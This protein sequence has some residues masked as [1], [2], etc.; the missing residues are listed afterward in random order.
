MSYLEAI[1]AQIKI[2]N[3]NKILQLW[4]EYCA[5][6]KVDPIEL[7][8]ILKAF[9]ASDFAKSMGKY[10]EKGL[11]LWK[12]IE[13]SQQ[14]YE[15]L[16]QLIDLQTTNNAALA[17]LAVAAVTAR[18]GVKEK[19]KFQEWM[20]L[21]GLSQRINF[22]GALSSFDLLHHM[23][24]GRF[25]FHSGGWGIGEI[26]DLSPIRQ[27]A[28][29]E[30]EN[31]V[32]LKHLTFLNAFKVLEPMGEEHFLVRRF[33]FADALEAAAKDDPVAVIK[34]MLKD[35]GPKN[36]G[37][38]KEL[39]YEWVIPT[40]QWNRWW[41]N[42]RGKLKKDSFVETPEALKNPFRLRNEAITAEEH[43]KKAKVCISDPVATLRSAYNMMRDLN[44]GADG[45]VIK[46]SLLQS[47]QELIASDEIT[48]ANRLEAAL[49][50]ETTFE[51]EPPVSSVELIQGSAPQDLVETICAMD[52]VALKKRACIL[53]KES[54]VDFSHIFLALLVAIQQGMLRDY[55]MK[56][57]NQG[58]TKK[59]LEHKLREL[60]AYPTRY[61][62]LLVWY[63]HKIITHKDS[64]LPFSDKEGQ[65]LFFEAFLILFVHL[66]QD[67]SSK[68]LLKKMYL[69]L[70]GKRYAIV[71]EVIEG[72]SLDF[73]KEFLL[74]VVKCQTLTDHDLKIMRSLSEVVHPS[75]AEKKQRKESHLDG[76]ILW[77]TEKGVHAIQ[78]RARQIGTIEVI[79]NAKEIEAA[80]A[81]G[82]LRENSEYKF[83][84]EKRSRLQNEL[85]RISDQIKRSRIITEADT[86][87]EEVDIGSV[88]TLEDQQGKQTTYTL[89]GP[90]E[91]EPDN[92]IL[93]FQSKFAQAMLGL[94]EGDVFPFRTDEY[95]VVK[96]ATVFDKGH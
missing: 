84:L 43:L 57:L 4:E 51:L 35:L 39:L 7:I 41:Q 6:D 56:E 66:E 77:A 21:V 5:D 46:S 33:A 22:Q 89:L 75:L 94:K 26:I 47:I 81:L 55:L 13:D 93:S 85:K 65:C 78:E 12:K 92:N 64:D 88:V 82:D 29:I 9:K 59:L 83:A 80:R 52:I 36:A 38:I 31:V 25:V 72:T 34:S 70:S 16:K 76:H 27:Q 68:D 24:K 18:Y 61:P 67:P 8:Q 95:K 90:L 50:L 37:E 71:R 62:D 11:L 32:G 87:K 10:I 44:S 1:Q 63:F 19:D 74:L 30:F 42:T 3:L 2:R 91:A 53:V 58:E 79:Q 69:M 20:R 60:L 15:V 54:R 23:A 73:I 17:D 45:E 28:T 14:G 48:P 49:L 40:G 96:L 86:S